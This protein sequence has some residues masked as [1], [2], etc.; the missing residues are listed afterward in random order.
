MGKRTPGKWVSSG[1]Y[2]FAN[3]VTHADLASFDRG[4]C[5]MQD[6]A[7]ATSDAAYAAAA[8]RAHDDLC[9]GLREALEA[10]EQLCHELEVAGE[11]HS[12]DGENTAC[13]VCE[14]MHA[15][16]KV[17]SLADYATLAWQIAHPGEAFE[18]EVTK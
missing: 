14:A 10:L 18:H 4:Q 9:D 1:N 6:D 17:L 16:R 7:Q 15:A 2:L 3:A 5:T 13:A 12:S 11:G 8:V